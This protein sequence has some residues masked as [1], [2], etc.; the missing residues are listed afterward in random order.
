MISRTFT[1]ADDHSGTPVPIVLH[2][3]TEAD[4]CWECRYSIG[5]PEGERTGVVRGYD[6]MQALYLAMQKI[7]V[8]LY[9]SPYHASGV[10]Q[11]DKPGRGYG[12]PMP[13]DGY[14][15][16]IGDDRTAQVPD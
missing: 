7:A 2:V 8:E 12:F 15:D 9:C 1:I 10:L 5:W 11:W 14:Q 16:L 3:P 6:G 4:R 13:K